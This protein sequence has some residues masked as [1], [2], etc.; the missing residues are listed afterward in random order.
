MAIALKILCSCLLAYVAAALSEV[1]WHKYLFH[2]NSIGGRFLSGLWGYNPNTHAEH[3][4]I[5]RS[6]MED[7]VVADA[8]YWVQRPSNVAVAAIFAVALELA[9]LAALQFAS[10]VLLLNAV[11]TFVLFWFWYL[12]EDHFHLAMHKKAYYQRHI[13]GTWQQG[14]LRYLRRLHAIHHR[15]ST[16]NYGFVFFP[17]GD[18]LIGTY[19][20]RFKKLRSRHPIDRR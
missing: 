19:R 15:D 3:H 9:L 14:W 5:C 4:T 2:S 17:V 18:L 16:C 12:F 11:L 8:E 10:W 1:F 7:Q 20:P 6:S 13:E